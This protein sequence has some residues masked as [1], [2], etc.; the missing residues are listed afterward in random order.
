MHGM[1]RQRNS[2]VIAA[3]NGGSTSGNRAGIIV[4]SATN[5]QRGMD[6][7]ELCLAHCWSIALSS[8]YCIA[9]CSFSASASIAAAR[10][11]SA[12]HAIHGAIGVSEEHDLQL[13]TRR[14]RDTRLA[15][16]GEAYWAAL[17]GRARLAG[18]V[19]DSIEFVRRLT[20]HG[21]RSETALPQL[22]GETVVNRTFADTFG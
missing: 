5:F 11:V 20:A 16:G 7:R 15:D 19:G 13:Y 3:G 6:C 10:I 14:L 4:G 12:G 22:G 18:D 2:V 9:R 21:D 17:I 8:P 1:Y